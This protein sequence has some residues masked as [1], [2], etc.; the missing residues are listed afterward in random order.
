TLA[1][2]QKVGRFVL[3]IYGQIGLSV[4]SFLALPALVFYPRA[5]AWKPF[6]VLL[7]WVLSCILMF[8]ASRV[9]GGRTGWRRHFARVPWIAAAFAGLGVLRVVATAYRQHQPH[10]IT[11]YEAA[12]L[13]ASVLFFAPAGY[14]L[15]RRRPKP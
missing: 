12:W 4:A 7:V 14:L 2:R 1:G 9:S 13:I 15:C 5:G 10:S 6:R 3:L 8:F 11:N